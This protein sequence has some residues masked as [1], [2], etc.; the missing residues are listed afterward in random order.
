[1]RF[2]ADVEVTDLSDEHDVVWV[3]RRE[4]YACRRG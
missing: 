3:P 2:L 1:M 4:Q